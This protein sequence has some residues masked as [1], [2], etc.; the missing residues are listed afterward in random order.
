MS[1]PKEFYD[2]VSL[3]KK[4]QRNGQLRGLDAARFNALSQALT[5]NDQESAQAVGDKELADEKQQGD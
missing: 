3:Y 2:Y 1:D 4:L 5:K